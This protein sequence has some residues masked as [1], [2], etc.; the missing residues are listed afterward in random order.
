MRQSC[1]FGE[2]PIRN[3]V[4]SEISF[5]RPEVTPEKEEFSYSEVQPHTPMID[6]DSE[7]ICGSYLSSELMRLIPVLGIAFQIS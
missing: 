3:V 2:F 5:F 1:V 6:Q 4:S 7:T